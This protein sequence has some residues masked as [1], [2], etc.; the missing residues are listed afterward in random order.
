MGLLTDIIRERIGEHDTKERERRDNIVKGYFDMISAGVQ[1]KTLTQ[2]QLDAALA[3]INK[4]YGKSKDAK[5]LTQRYGGIVGKMLSAPGA[6]PPGQPGQAPQG[7]QAPQTQPAPGGPASPAPQEPKAAAQVMPPPQAPAAPAAPAGPALPPPQGVSLVPDWAKAQGRELESERAKQT[8]IGERERGT[9]AFQTS[10]DVRK[11]QLMYDQRKTQADDLGLTGEAK[12][13]FVATGKY[14]TSTKP[15]VIKGLER[16]GLDGIWTKLSYADGSVEWEKQGPTATAIRVTA[17]EA[18]TLPH[19]REL[20]SQGKVYEDESG[21]PLDLN[22]I[23]DGMVIQAVH[24]GARTF[25]TTR[26]VV[27]KAVT[28]GGVMYAVNPYELQQLPAGAGTRVGVT[29]I[30]SRGTTTQVAVDPVTGQ[31]V[32]NTLPS[33]RVP[34]ATGIPGRPE[35]GAPSPTAPPARVPGQAPTG[36]T[37][38]PTSP[39]PVP[40][41]T[42]GLRG[43]PMGQLNPMLQRLTPVRESYSQVFGDPSQP[44]FTPLSSYADLADDPKASAKIGSALRYTL[45][46][47]NTA[48]S[49]SKMGFWSWVH[50]VSGFSNE[51]SRA[52]AQVL[53]GA[54]GQ[55]NPRETEAYNASIDA[56]STAIGLRSLS[57][58]SAA[59]A[60]VRR[61]EADLPMIGINVKGSRAFYDKLVRLAEI[62]YN[63]SVGLPAV[64]FK[65][66]ELEGLKAL[67][68]K[69]KALR[70]KAPTEGAR[71]VLGG[72]RQAPTVG[73][74]RGGFRFKGGDPAS[75]S[76]WEKVS[77]AG[78]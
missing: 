56:I 76:S 75:R 8:A 66:G 48:E 1:N 14:P 45:D 49:N 10:E 37:P 69:M 47:L 67:P 57:R 59:Q 17:S 7:G 44:E 16:E 29:A 78:R 41:S 21:K 50:D 74:V 77:S 46:Q 36:A 43:V 32:L 3:N 65:P 51:L 70:D 52:R 27:D 34:A 28:V 26:D 25:Y 58:A 62:T 20:A 4:E 9:T 19:A 33:T 30:P 42:P 35:P 38:R 55:L 12:N 73:E 71:K 6:Q 31:L 54:V 64:M 63:G 22:S 61:I 68:S 11:S 15:L 39:P 53:Q 18:T 2:E 13:D 40:G 23:P 5:A 72:P 24:Q 60:S